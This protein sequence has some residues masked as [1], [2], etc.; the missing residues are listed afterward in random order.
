M[1]I[2]AANRGEGLIPKIIRKTILKDKI[3]KFFIFF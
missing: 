1:R 3:I 2:K